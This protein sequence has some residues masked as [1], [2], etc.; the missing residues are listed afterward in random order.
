MKKKNIFVK[1]TALV[2]VVMATQIS[3]AQDVAKNIEKDVAE[4]K[5]IYQQNCV[6]CHQA[7]AIGKPGFAPSLSNEELLSIASDDFLYRTIFNGRIGTSMIPFKHLGGKKIYQIIGYLRSLTTKPNRSKEVEAQHD[8]HGDPRLGKI[9]FED[10]CATCHGVEGD[11]YLSG[12]TGTAIGNK[13]FLK[14]VSDGFLRE[15]IKHGRSNTRMLSFSGPTGLANLSDGE[16]EDI[17]AYI[18]TF[19]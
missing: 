2:L 6:F 10:I 11:G 14:V 17:I 18:R 15:T 9:W 5:K 13:N 19:Y 7:D 1:L 12:S 8:S 4:G 16:I 3:Y